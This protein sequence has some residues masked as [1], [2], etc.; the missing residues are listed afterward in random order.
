M[1]AEIILPLVGATE[2]SLG[3]EHL[4]QHKT[5]NVSACFV[6]CFFLETKKNKR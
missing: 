3:D 6:R 2:S 5:E 4:P 1:M